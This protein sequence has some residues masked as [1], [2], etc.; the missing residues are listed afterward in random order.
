MMIVYKVCARRGKEPWRSCTVDKGRKPSCYHLK[1]TT[2]PFP[3]CGP[4]AAFARKEDAIRFVEICNFV[5]YDPPTF[6]IFKCRANKAKEEKLYFRKYKYSREANTLPQGTLL[7]SSV[8]LIER[9][10]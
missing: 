1:E 7:V 10:L 8:T 9:V 2:V 3:G 6:A 5:W 4:L